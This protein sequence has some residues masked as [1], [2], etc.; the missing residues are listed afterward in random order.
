MRFGFR[1]TENYFYAL[2]AL[3]FITGTASCVWG[4]FRYGIDTHAHLLFLAGVFGC[5]SCAVVSAIRESERE[6]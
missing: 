3:L 4:L 6:G 1:K 5:L 2:V